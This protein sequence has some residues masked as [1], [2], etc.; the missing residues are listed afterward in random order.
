MYSQELVSCEGKVFPCLFRAVSSVILFTRAIYTHFF[1]VICVCEC[2][3][4]VRLISFLKEIYHM[5]K[6]LER[7]KDKMWRRY[8][9]HLNKFSNNH[10]PQ[11]GVKTHYEHITRLIHFN[12]P[13]RYQLPTYHIFTNFTTITYPNRFESLS[14]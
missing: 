14:F 1:P 8:L 9:I 11:N 2:G 7:K 4:R 13:N 3:V 12:I 5:Y 6:N 10:L